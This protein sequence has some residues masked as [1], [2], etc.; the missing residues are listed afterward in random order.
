MEGSLT[1]TIN[2]ETP[3]QEI[4][5]NFN[6]GLKLSLNED[7]KL[8]ELKNI[9]NKEFMLR[10]DEYEIY[11]KDVQLLIINHELKI[12]TLIQTYQTNEFT[13]KAYKS[14]IKFFK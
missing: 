14:K 8:T 11:I 4:I 6:H 3:S 9:I 7:S 10:D 12:S 1:S 2:T 5:V 13:V